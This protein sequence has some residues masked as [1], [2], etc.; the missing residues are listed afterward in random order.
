MLLGLG[1]VGLGGGT[2]CGGNAGSPAP[3]SNGPGSGDVK[4]VDQLSGSGSSFVAP[5]MTKKWAGA[6]NKAKG[7]LIDYNSIG[8]GAGVS[9][10]IEK[11]ND[12][13]ASDA[14]L[15]EEQ[16][17]KA[18]AAG[19]D[20]IYV[21]LVLGAVVPFYNLPE[22]DQPVN[23]AGPI[24]ADIFLGNI[25]KWNDP[26]LVE[27]NKDAKLPDL[28]IQVAVRADGSGTSYIWTDYLSKVSPEWKDKVGRN[29]QPNW[30][31][32]N[33]QNKS[34]GVA[35]LVAQTKGGIGYV[36]LAYAKNKKEIK[37]GRVKN[38]AGNFVIASL[39]A[40]NA[41]TESIKEAD[42]PDDLAFSITDADGKDAYPIVGATWAVLFVKQPRDRAGALKDFFSW[43]IHDGQGMTRDLDYG[44]LSR[45]LVDRAQQKIDT[46]VS[47]H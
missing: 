11:K 3:G 23:F 32:G 16:A 29:T 43:T 9:Q 18:R 26:R 10:M 15:N 2:G 25:K 40:T 33:R 30:P 1:L 21:P 41:A 38:K 47:S 7:I 42:I 34:D 27:I 4:Q 5:L 12:F 13:A 39:E 17:G 20:F 46:I 45:P 24:L 19:G 36:E 8:S 14:P 35:G 31:V 6:F 44:A 37:Y 28:D 22:V